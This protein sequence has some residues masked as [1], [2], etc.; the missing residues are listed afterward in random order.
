MLIP[1]NCKT[2][3]K[4]LFDLLTDIISVLPDEESVL[5]DRIE[6]MLKQCPALKD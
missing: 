1:S 4:E 6:T 2:Y 3:K 5:K